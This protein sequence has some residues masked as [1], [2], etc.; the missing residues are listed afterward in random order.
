MRPL[1]RSHRVRT[2][3]AVGLDLWSPGAHPG[4]VHGDLRVLPGF[5]ADPFV[6][7]PWADT[8]GDP[9]RQAYTA[10]RMLPS[11]RPKTSAPRLSLSRLVTTAC[12][13][14]VYASW[15][16]LLLPPRKTRFRW[17]ASPCRV[18]F[19]PTGSTTKGFRFC[20]LH[21]PS[22]LPRLRLARGASLR[23]ADLDDPP[24]PPGDPEM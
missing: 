16:G 4:F 8:P 10:P 14:A 9:R 23:R 2:P 18:G 22:S 21:M 13:L 12:T 11:A 17:G 20:L 1:I 19:G 5:W 6:Y 3:S 15:R 24:H 7:M